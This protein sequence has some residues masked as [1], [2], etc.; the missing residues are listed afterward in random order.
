MNINIPVTTINIPNIFLAHQ[1]GLAKIL[2]LLVIFIHPYPISNNMIDN[3]RVYANRL[4]NHCIKF[5]GNIMATI[6]KYVGEQLLKTGP[7]APHKNIS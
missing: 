7:N 4:V 6:I 5:A 3:H 2:S 1:L